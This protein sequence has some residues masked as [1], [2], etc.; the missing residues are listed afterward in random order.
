MVADD[1]GVSGPYNAGATAPPL[2]IIFSPVTV[3]RGSSYTTMAARSV[4]SDHQG[5]QSILHQLNSHAIEVSRSPVTTGYKQL[6]TSQLL[7]AA[8]SVSSISALICCL[9]TTYTHSSADEAGDGRG[10]QVPL[11]R[12]EGGASAMVRALTS[13]RLRALSRDEEPAAPHVTPGSAPPHPAA[14]SSRAPAA[15]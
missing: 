8:Q 5:P 1:P 10:L 15:R 9:A 13:R 6:P 11:K 7:T 12:C 4:A 2:V 3:L 14:R